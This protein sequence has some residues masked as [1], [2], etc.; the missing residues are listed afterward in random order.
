MYKSRKKEERAENGT[1]S[2]IEKIAA[3]IG[4]EKYEE[5]KIEEKIIDSSKIKIFA[6]N[7]DGMR[8]PL[9]K[10]SNGAAFFLPSGLVSAPLIMEVEKFSCPITTGAG[11][12]V[13]KIEIELVSP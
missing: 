1:P 4:G 5:K 12:T 11:S 8:I 7:K 9:M 10:N 2:I 3:K 6:L 13:L